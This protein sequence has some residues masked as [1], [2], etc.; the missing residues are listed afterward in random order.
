MSV[1]VKGMEM[2][3]GELGSVPVVI[4]ADGAVCHFFT[5]EKLGNAIPVPAHGDLIDRD[6]IVSW[7][8]DDEPSPWKAPFRLCTADRSDVK[9]LLK[10]APTIIPAEPPKEET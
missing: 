6:A 9:F 5:H 8:Y 1:L 4:F 2:P 10:N 7:L 3:K